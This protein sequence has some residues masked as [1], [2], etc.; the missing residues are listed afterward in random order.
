M[1]D[2][3]N[4]VVWVDATSLAWRLAVAD[5]LGRSLPSFGALFLP[6][7]FSRISLVWGFYSLTSFHYLGR[8]GIFGPHGV[9][10]W[11]QTTGISR[12]TCLCSN[13]GFFLQSS[14]FQSVN[15]SF[16]TVLEASE[17]FRPFPSS[18]SLNPCYGGRMK[19]IREEYLRTNS[20]VNCT[21]WRQALHCLA[22]ALA[23]SW[24]L[25]AW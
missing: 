18:A 10:L 15:R 3:G 17:I 7:S 16:E 11:S 5:V 1:R 9:W 19:I 22:H 21:V 20:Q 13:R 12:R 14:T 4:E 23:I 8:R 2:P 24:D 25:S 6:G